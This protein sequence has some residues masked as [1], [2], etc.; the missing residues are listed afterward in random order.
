MAELT[1]RLPDPHPRQKTFIDSEA[2]RKVIRAGR[3]GGK[4]VGMAVMAVQKF[5]A[6]KRVLY[7]APTVDQLHSFWFEVTKALVDPVD[8]GVFYKNETDHVIELRGTKQRIR[9]KTAYNADTLRGDY[10]DELI[11]DEYQLMD[12]D[13]WRLVGSPMLADNNGNATFVYTPPSLHSRSAS[14]A[15][16]PQHAA[17]LFKRAKADT[18]GRWA[19]FHFSSYDNP[20]IS[21]EA[22]DDLAQD[23]TALAYRMEIQAEDV[24]EAPGALWT[25][26]VIDDNRIS[27]QEGPQLDRVVVAVD[28][29]A[30]ADGDEAGIVVVGRGYN[31]GYVLADLSIQGSPQ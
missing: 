6:G 28:P 12:E 27:E 16:D 26:A 21:S 10:A 1:V 29:S 9:A 31:H 13:T 14:K 30:T 2:K 5:L 7:A 8:A 20:H 25:R 15:T 19:T 24:D 18:S 11:L 4:T 3:R 22:L 23:M 17:K